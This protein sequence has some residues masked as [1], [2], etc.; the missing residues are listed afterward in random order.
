MT[1]TSRAD[2]KRHNN[3][4]QI[5]AISDSQNFQAKGALQISSRAAGP[6]FFTDVVI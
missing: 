2:G 1:A 6:I 5:T 4:V 3:E